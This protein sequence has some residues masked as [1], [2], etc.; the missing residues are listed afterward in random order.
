MIKKVLEWA[1]SKFKPS[2][3][4]VAAWP[5]PVVLGTP[6]ACPKKPVAKKRGRPATKKVAVKKTTKKKVK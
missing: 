4:E 5:F 6:P 1:L 2:K 3:E